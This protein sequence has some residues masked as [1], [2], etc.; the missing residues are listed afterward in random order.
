M[1]QDTAFKSYKSPGY[2]LLPFF[3]HS[4][5]QWKA[6]AQQR[7]HRIRLQQSRIG[8]LETSRKKW[9]ELARTY[10]SRCEELARQLE[11]QKS[12]SGG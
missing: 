11:E 7:H 4:R 9:K 6:K 12:D 1:A 5:D 3:E 2:K 10:R 8:A